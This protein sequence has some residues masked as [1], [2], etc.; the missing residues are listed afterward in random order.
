[1][2]S[3]TLDLLSNLVD[4]ITNGELDSQLD[5]IAK[6]VEDRRRIV[7]S[8]VTIEDFMVGDKITINERC[9]TK[10]LVGELA[11]V[12]G[13]RRTKLTIQFETPKGRFIRK[14]A[15]G[16]TYSSDVVVPIE[17]VDRKK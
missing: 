5:S 8:G 9:G 16:T 14:N 3:L 13:I 6:A 12:V 4:D 10:Y 17:I 1:M 2:S 7:R 11:T 15:D